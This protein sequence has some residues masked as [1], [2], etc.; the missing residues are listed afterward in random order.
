MTISV[1]R[2]KAFALALAA[3]LALAFGITV[4]TASPAAAAGTFRLCNVSSDYSA[5]ATF[6]NSGGFSTRVVQPGQCTSVGLGSGTVRYSVTI[7]G[8]WANSPSK[9]TTQY[10]IPSGRSA[11]FH[12][13]G[14]FA[15]PQYTPLVY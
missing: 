3:A 2:G 5:Q 9:T 14:T 13:G 8:N 6:A 1:S 7:K 15:S 12:A 10:S 4:G 11:D